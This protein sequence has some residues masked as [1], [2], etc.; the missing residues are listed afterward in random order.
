MMEEVPQFK[1]DSD[2]ENGFYRIQRKNGLCKFLDG[3][4]CSIYE[5][6]PLECRLYPYILHYENSEVVLKL[7]NDCP[8]KQL[9][10]K[11]T[12]PESIKRYPK[13]WWEE[14]NKLSI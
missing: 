2:E 3:N 7:H 12:I 1:N 10:P 9:A 13:E 5:I 8:Q 11:P 4:K 6:R 14:W